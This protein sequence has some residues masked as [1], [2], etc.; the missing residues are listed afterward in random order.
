MFWIGLAIGGG[1]GALA[2]A[3]ISLTLL[4]LSSFPVA[5]LVVNTLG[6]FAIGCCWVWFNRY[7]ASSTVTGLVMTGFLGGFTTFSTFSLESLQLLQQEHYGVAM[8]Y[9]ALSLLLC[10]FAVSAGVI[11]AKWVI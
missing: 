8:L 11:L 10:L 7:G 1:C 2:R 6:S 5:T 4:P 3:W 9:M